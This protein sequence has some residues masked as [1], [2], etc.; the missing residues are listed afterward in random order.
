MIMT[1]TLLRRWVFGAVLC[2]VFFVLTC[3]NMFTAGGIS[4]PRAEDT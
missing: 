2:H 1:T 3:V 4:L